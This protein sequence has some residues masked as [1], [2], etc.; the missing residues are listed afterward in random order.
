[1]GVLLFFDKLKNYPALLD[2]MM[3]NIPDIVAGDSFKNEMKRFLPTNVH[4]RTLGKNKF[5]GFLI[6]TMRNLLKDT[7]QCL[8]DR[9]A[10]QEFPM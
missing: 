1:M 5:E 7:K 3:A 9:Q 2:T 8:N 6:N 10:E 4:D